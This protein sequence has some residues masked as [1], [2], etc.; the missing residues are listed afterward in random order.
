ML[1]Q[2]APPNTVLLQSTSKAPP[3][4]T[5]PSHLPGTVPRGTIALECPSGQA[6]HRVQSSRDGSEQFLLRKSKP[7]PAGTQGR[8]QG[9]QHSSVSQM[10]ATQKA[11]T[12]P[13]AK[14]N[15]GYWA[16][17]PI[18]LDARSLQLKEQS[19]GKCCFKEVPWPSL[20]CASTRL[21]EL[22]QTPVWKRTM[23]RRGG[24]KDLR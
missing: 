16:T 4:Q 24:G 23:L 17:A 20:S 1:T 8:K 21:L 5:I 15:G 3:M 2:P 6:N 10:K 11:T 9:S 12:H 19:L 7:F 14:H 18:S 22:D 13:A